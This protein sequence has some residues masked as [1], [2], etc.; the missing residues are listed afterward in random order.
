MSVLALL[1]R[2]LDKTILLNEGRHDL[3]G[4]ETLSKVLT[5]AAARCLEALQML[6]HALA[7][8][9]QLIF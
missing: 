3:I 2:L 9:D 8:R 5:A 6:H 4:L 1:D 7:L